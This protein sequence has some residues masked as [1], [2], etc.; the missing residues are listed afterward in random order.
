TAQVWDLRSDSRSLPDLIELAQL[1][2]AERTDTTGSNVPVETDAL[3]R[4]WK[5]LQ[6]RYR[7]TFV[8]TMEQVLAWHEREAADAEGAREWAAALP[9]LDAL[10]AAQPSGAGLHTRRGVAH[11]ELDHWAAAA[12][13][14]GQA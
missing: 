6:P 8:P 10:L 14:F 2:S 3:L 13:D 1:L 9:H 12:R 11:A 4:T 7:A 5:R